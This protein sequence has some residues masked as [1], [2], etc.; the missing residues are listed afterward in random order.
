MRFPLVM[1]LA[2]SACTTDDVQ[3]ISSSLECSPNQ[4]ACDPDAPHQVAVPGDVTTVQAAVDLVADG[5]SIQLASGTYVESLVITGKQ[6]HLRGVDDT[7]LRGAAADQ[8]VVTFRDGGGG[9]IERLSITGGSRGVSG[10]NAGALAIDRVHLHRSGRGVTGEFAALEI[11]D[12]KV[13]HMVDGGV[14]AR[15]INA[16]TIE[17]SEIFKV[18]GAGIQVE[19]YGE[20]ADCLHAFIG[21]KV[22]FNSRGGLAVYGNRCRVLVFGGRYVGNGFAAVALVEAGSTVV[23]GV[24]LS[25]TQE[26]DGLF[27]DG[28][29]AWATTVEARFVSSTRNAGSGL[30]AYGCEGG[31]ES[32]VSIGDSDLTCNVFDIVY[33]GYPG[34]VPAVEINDEGGNVCGCGA[35]A[36][37]RAVTSTFM[38]VKVPIIP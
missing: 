34:C 15:V 16:V 38:P 26:L 35:A 27:G 33:D 28:L 17:R 10:H 31:R 7:V 32:S 13:K 11:V 21:N 22:S 6:V 36:G 12:S 18:G 23:H 20:P 29:L 9:R 3:S 37:C 30:A 1:L 14:L 19:S 5:G 25:G 8:P 2:V 24:E 4:Q